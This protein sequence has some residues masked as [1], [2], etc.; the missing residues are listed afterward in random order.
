MSFGVAGRIIRLEKEKEGDVE[1]VVFNMG[2]CLESLSSFL[3]SIVWEVSV[4]PNVNKYILQVFNIQGHVLLYT[5]TFLC[6]GFLQYSGEDTIVF[7]IFCH[8]NLYNSATTSS[9]D[10]SALRRCLYE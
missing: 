8:D 7:V 2:S 4:N 1:K 6:Q 10:S 9:A 5:A 3:K